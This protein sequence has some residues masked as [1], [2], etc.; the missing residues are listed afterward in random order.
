MY[1]TSEPITK[2][3]PKGVD[4]EEVMDMNN[5]KILGARGEP[6]APR[7]KPKGFHSYRISLDLRG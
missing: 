7:Y 4:E 3:N 6:K 5:H 1:D 2:K